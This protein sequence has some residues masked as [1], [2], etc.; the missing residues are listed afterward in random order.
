MN[1]YAKETQRGARPRVVPVHTTEKPPAATA[2]ATTPRVITVK[3]EAEFNEV[4]AKAPGGV[5]ADFSM[6]G[7]GR[8]EDEES[9]VEKIAGECPNVTVVRIDV[10][11]APALADRFEVMGTPTYLVAGNAAGMVPGVAKEVELDGLR[12]S[13]KCARTKKGG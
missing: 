10:D 5:V 4:V 3:T 13:I 2:P 8:C 1:R 11:D 9:E 12:K 6:E 7:C